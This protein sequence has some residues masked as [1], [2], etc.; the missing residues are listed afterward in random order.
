MDHSVTICC[1]WRVFAQ[2]GIHSTAFTVL[3]ETTLQHSTFSWN[4]LYIIQR[5]LA[6]VEAIYINYQCLLFCRGLDWCKECWWQNFPTVCGGVADIS[7]VDWTVQNTNISHIF[8]YSWQPWFVPS[9]FS[10]L[11]FSLCLFDVREVVWY[12]NDES[13]FLLL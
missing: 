12:N 6:L 1:F 13:V 8:R 9:V 5:A 3:L 4:P 10:W 11:C 7:A 2:T